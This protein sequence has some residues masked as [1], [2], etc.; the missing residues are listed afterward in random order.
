MP[1]N[2][3]HYPQP[4]QSLRFSPLTSASRRQCVAFV[5]AGF[6]APL[7]QLTWKSLLS[8][9]LEQTARPK[10]LEKEQAARYEDLKAKLVPERPSA[11][12]YALVAQ[13]FDACHCVV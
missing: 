12:D 7:T 6:T 8:E 5:G 10:L 11:E 4:Q 3:P 13:V 2:A 1:R 9:L